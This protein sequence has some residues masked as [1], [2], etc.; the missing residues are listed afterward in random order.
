VIKRKKVLFVAG[1]R[2]ETGDFI[3]E[4]FDAIRA[5]HDVTYLHIDFVKAFEMG[6]LWSITEKYQNGDTEEVI[7]TI[8]CYLRRWGIFETL[9]RKAISAFIKRHGRMY[10]LVHINVRTPIT[11]VVPS[12]P[13]LKEVPIILTEHSSFYHTG[14]DLRYSDLRKRDIEIERIKAWFR[15]TGIIHVMPVSQQLG[16]VLVERFGV[17]EELIRV[18]PNVAADTFRPMP[19]LWRKND[20]KVHLLMVAFWSYPKNLMLFARALEGL[21]ADKRERIDIQFVG[22]G[23]LVPEFQSFLQTTM[24]GLQI[25]YHGT[26]SNK[27]DLARLYNSADLLVHP[28]D[29]ENL[30]CVIIESHCCGTPVLSN[31]LNGIVEL[32]KPDKNGLLADRQDVEGFRTQLERF[33]DGQVRFD[34]AAISERAL[35]RFSAERVARQIDEIYEETV[36]VGGANTLN[37]DR[38]YQQCSTCV[39]DTRDDPRIRFDMAGVCNYC[40]EYKRLEERRL[41]KGSDRTK[42]L[43]DLIKRIKTEG[44]GKPH[45]CVLGVSGGVDSTYVAVMLKERGL[46]PLLVHLD[47]GWNSERAV[48][49]IQQII[50]RLDMDLYTYVIDWEEFRDI[51]LAFLEASIVDIEL[52][53]DLAIVSCLYNTA[54]ERGIKYIISG[55]NFATE[56]IMPQNWTHEKSDLLNLAAIYKHYFGRDLKTFPKLDYFKKNYLV[57]VKKI[58]VLPILNYVDYHKEAAKQEMMEKLQW[59]DYGSKHGESIFTKFYQHYILP[60]KFNIDKRK[61]HLSSLICSGQLTKEEALAELQLPLYL[62][63]DLKADLDY[64]IKKFGLTKE[65]F[66]AIMRSPIRRHT[67]F[68]SY[69][70]QHMARE[71]IWLKRLKPITRLVKKATGFNPESN[72]V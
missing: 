18:V 61:A 23:E 43:N 46:R 38:N 67:D 72:Y 13:E 31:S 16:S 24:P 35:A 34:R 12:I 65:E 32:I 60:E 6:R 17:R 47:N 48:R 9:I 2:T 10:D 30:P 54:H 39:M 15:D 29:A 36:A 42:L 33:I 52:V 58:K 28:S 37:L 20:D 4:H 11:E 69:L 44:A 1:W 59:Q 53:T 5:H 19:D 21:P 14:V 22:D 41:F 27:Q 49:N 26:I 57:F 55:H 3:R 25:S 68:P 40:H 71:R 66:D 7:I 45:D 51:Q 62:P 63:R 70:T 50:D 64:V 8:T 56:S